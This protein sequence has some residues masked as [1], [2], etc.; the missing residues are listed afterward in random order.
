MQK[1]KWRINQI[2]S[3]QN[4]NNY[5][6]ENPDLDDAIYLSLEVQIDKSTMRDLESIK[7]KG[8][9]DMSIKYIKDRSFG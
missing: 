9:L 4:V 5:E 2:K 1:S 6:D 7:I 8:A 3:S